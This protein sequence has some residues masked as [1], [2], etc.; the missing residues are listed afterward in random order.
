M[1]IGSESEGSPDGLPTKDGNVSKTVRLT[2]MALVGVLL[3]VLALAWFLESPWFRAWLEDQAGRQL[4]G[5]EV[6][7]GELDIA[8][9]LPVTVRL[10][11]LRI[12][13][14]DWAD[15]D[16]M[17][18]V[19]ELAITLNPI[20]LLQGEIELERVAAE[21]PVIHLAR[22][23]DGT[24][25][26][27]DVMDDEAEGDMAFW[28]RSFAIG[29]GRL[30]YRDVALEAL[31]DIEFETPGDVD[32]L[33]LE[34]SGEGRIRDDSLAFR[35]EVLYQ[36]EEWRGAV[37][38]LEGRIGD[39]RV[40]GAAMVDLGREVPRIEVQLDADELD[41]NRWGLLD[42][43]NGTGAGPA[44]T[45]PLEAWE[46]RL[47]DVWEV[48]E[49]YEARLDVAIDR[50]HYA[51]QSLHDLALKGSLE[52]G[53]LDM[54]RL[55]ATQ[56]VNGE[57]SGGL[58]VQGIIDVREQRLAADV[59]AEFD[60]VDLTA[61]LAPLGVGEL[62]MLA[63]R[64]NT[65]I[66]DGGLVVDDTALDYRAPHW[67]LALS[68]RADSS[69]IA[70]TDRIGVHLVGDG[71]HEEEPFAFDLVVGP[72]LDLASPDTPYPV[73]GS[74]SSGD[75]HLHLDGSIVQPLE[76][77]AV[78]GDFRLEGPN[79]ADLTDLTGLNLPELPPYELRS[80]LSFS[81]DLLDLNGLQG[82]F[83]ESDVEGDVR[84]ALGERP[85][86]WAT[87]TTQVLE[88]DD[89]LPMLGIAP[90][91]DDG[92]V[93]P[94]QQQWAEEDE[95]RQRLFPDRPWDLEALRGTD[96]VLDY[97]AEN[98]EARHVPFTDVSLQ[99]TLEQGVMTVEPLQVGLGGGQ[100]SASW[101]MDARQE[102]LEGD[103]SLALDQVNLKAL[104]QEANLPEVAEDTLGMIGGRG[105][106]RYRGRSMDEVMAGLAGELELAMS[107]G[108]L[109]IIAA[110]LLPL[111][112]A[113]AM[114]AAL[115]GEDQVELQCS[116]VHFVVE[117]GLATLDQF[118]MATEIAHFTGEG[119]IDLDHEVL[120][121]AFEGHNKDVTFFT[122]NSPVELEGP[123]REPE[124]NVITTELMVRGV[125]SLVGALI[126]PPTAILPWV[127][128]GGG[129]E[130]GMGCEQALAEFED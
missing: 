99:M 61:A 93:S 128:L 96:I 66:V 54:D 114:I 127:E 13:N 101:V 88:A 65:R 51:D 87:L 27:D 20:A 41:L 112:V 7:I 43:R 26:W 56:H 84:I 116:Y 57:P 64:L 70:G 55:R 24:T 74:L 59:S 30:V 125:V 47:V 2:G 67:G 23:E 91:T 10:N 62:G 19:D 50:L 48:L 120:E 89:L 130:V 92:P 124:V 58:D 38:N 29:Q 75:T 126:A 33:H 1:L 110:E 115:T 60:S 100:V 76:L 77:D 102:A 17:V 95:R 98:V 107:Q 6:E 45:N 129:E 123:L 53:R 44:G 83:G 82:R 42:E 36:A 97:R 8:W 104:L 121:L 31:L 117:N 37:D 46:Q 4:D 105:Q 9:G 90:D 11:A 80:H 39:S 72:L 79:P 113:N 103:L 3:V 63:G 28:P 21:R 106:F 81:D 32:E 12:G 73:S 119:H 109:D 85:T 25:S 34:V 16:D 14:A 86:I 69:D 68:L 18:R 35:A 49:A 5:R 71:T 111:N 52:E 108:W 40:S 78:E 118:F 122:G 15:D 22:R 94:E